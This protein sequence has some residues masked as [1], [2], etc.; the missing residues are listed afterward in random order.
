[1]LS[2][3]YGISAA[4]H[5]AEPSVEQSPTADEIRFSVAA[6]L[7][8]R[9]QDL[10]ESDNLA[11]LGM[12]SIRT[13]SMA[14]WF[15][16]RGVPV[17]FLELVD[18]PTIAQ[19]SALVGSRLPEQRAPEDAAPPEAAGSRATAPGLDPDAP[20]PLTPV[21]HAYWIGRRDDQILGSV[22]CHAYFEF[23]GSSL[24]PERLEAAVRTVI[25]RHGMLRAVFLDDGTQ[26]IAPGGNW[27]GLTVHDLRHPLERPTVE[28]LASVRDALSHRRLRVE[29]GEVLDVQ[30]S[31][32]PG[33]A[34]RLHLNV[35]LLVA[36]VESIRILLADLAHAY[37][38]PE[39]PWVHQDCPEQ[40]WA[41]DDFGFAHY[42]ADQAGRRAEAR[43]QART[44][45]QG[46]LAD[47][48]DGPVLPLA[49]DPAD[50]GPPRFTRRRHR[51]EPDAWQRFSRRARQGGTTPAMA[52]AAA[53]AEVLGSFSESPRFLLSLPLFDRDSGHPAVCDMVADFTNLLLVTVDLTAGSSFLER[54]R[55]LQEEFRAG[56]AHSAYSGVEVLR[57]LARERPDEPR[58]APVVFACTLGEELAG[59][60]VRSVLGELGWMISQTPQVWLD[61][62]VYESGGGVEL[63]WDSVD[64][65]FPPELVVDMFACYREL[66]DRQASADAD[67]SAPARPALPA[68]QRSVR[69]RVNATAAPRSGRLLHEGFFARA[70]QVP[71]APALLWGTDSA[72]GYGSLAR[73]AL[74]VAAALLARGL[75]PGEPVAVSA[76]RGADQVAAVL[77]VLAAGGA[78]VP[79]GID[80][81]AR[82]RRRILERAG[83][84]LLLAEMPAPAD[85]PPGVQVLDLGS[86]VEHP[87]LAEPVPVSAEA[88]AYVIFTSGTTGE[89]KGVQV[90][91]GAAVNTVEDIN[92]RFSVG[93]SDRVLA[94]SALD[95]DLSVYDLFGLLAAGGAVVLPDESQRRDP[96]AWAE[97]ITRHRVTVWNSV[98]VLLDM[99]LTASAASTASTATVVDGLRLA[100]VSGDWIGLDLPGRLA[101]QSGSRFVALGGATEAAIWSNYYEVTEVPAS[102]TSVPYGFPLRNQRFRVVGPDGLDRPDRVA[103]ELWIGGAGVALGYLGDAGLTAAKF[104]THEG[105]RW[106]RTGDRGRY[107]PDGTL[108]FLGRID[109]QLKIRGVRTEPGEIES[110][111]RSHPAIGHCTVAAVGEDRAKRLLAVITASPVSVPALAAAPSDVPLSAEPHGAE[112]QLVEWVLARLAADEAGITAEPAPL[113]ELARRWGA[114]EEWQPL[115]RLWFDWLAAR[116]VLTVERDGYAAGPKLA[117]VCADAGTPDDQLA[118]VARRLR[119][120]LGDLAAV[121]R[122]E[123]DPLVLLDDPVLAPEA[124]AAVAPG[125]QLAVVALLSELPAGSGV[126]EI[127]VLGASGGRTALGLA[128]RAGEHR[129]TLLDESAARLGAA[130]ELLTDTPGR[131][132]YHRLPTGLLPAEL[133][134]RFDVVVAD[135]S[136]HGYADSATG[137]QLAVLLLAPGGLLLALERTVLPPLALIAAALPTR[138]FTRL[139][140]VRRAR[141]TPLLPAG[142]W[143]QVLADAGLRPAGSGASGA[144]RMDGQVL[145]RATRTAEA[146]L[147]TEQAIREWLA[148]RLP[149]AMI[150][151]HLFGA[152]ALPITANGKVDRAALLR[153]LPTS[154]TVPAGPAVGEPPSGPLES[155]IAAAWCEVLGLTGVGREQNFFGLGGD[156]LLATRLVRRLRESG[157]ELDLAAVFSSPVLKDLA[158]AAA[159]QPSTRPPSPAADA[160]TA[161]PEHRHDPFPPTDVQRAYWTGRAVG[162]PLGGVGAHYYTE[163]DGTGLDLARLEAAWNQLIAR[164]EMLRAVF[165]EHGEQRILAEVPHVPIPVG[166]AARDEAEE[167]LAAFRAAMSHQVRDPARWP[168]VDLR[169]LVYERD[170]EQRVRLGVSLENIVL[171]GRS[172]MIVLAELEQLYHAPDAVLRP[173]DGL[174]FRDYLLR[175]VPA[176][177]SD[178]ARRYWQDRLA[179]LPP[180]PRLPLAAHPSE[181]GTPRFVRR[182]GLLPADRWQ[183]VTSRARAY[184]LTP[185]AVLLAC[186]AE[187]LGRWSSSPELTVN[188]TLFDRQDVHPGV[189]DIVGDFTSLLLVAYQPEP[190]AGFLDRARALQQ[191]LGQDLS[192]RAWSAVRVV[193]ELARA[194]G[195]PDQGMPDQGMPVVFTSALGTPRALSLDLAD[196]LLPRVWGVSQTPQTW[197]DNQVY[198]SARGLHYDW[199][200]VEQLLPA[201]VLDAMFAAYGDLLDR[202]AESDWTAGV[203][204]LLP[205]AQLAVRTRVNATSGPLART[206]LHERFFA[207]A[208]QAPDRTAC[209]WAGGRLG[210]GELALRARQIAGLLHAHGIRPGCAVAVHLPK[211]PEQ[212]AAV[213]GVLAA[214]AAYVPIGVDQPAARRERLYSGAGVDC[215]LTTTARLEQAPEGVTVLSVGDAAGHDGY[216]PVEL[217]GEALAY[218]IFTSGSTGEPKGVEIAHQSALNTVTDVSERFGVGAED[219][220]LAVSALDFDLSVF[221]IFGPLSVGGSV[222]LIGEGERR[223]AQ[224]WLELIVEHRVSVWNSVPMLLEMLLAAARGPVPGLRLALVSGDWVGL[225]LKERLPGCRLV[226]L[227]GATEAS[228]WSNAWEV[229]G[230]PAGWPSIPYG[231]PLRNQWFRVVGSQ[232]RDCPD[233]VPGELWIGGAG[234]ALGYRGD[235][236]RTAE[237]F[238]EYGG[239]R[240]YRTGDLGRYRPDGRLEFLGRTDH[241]LKVSGHRIELGEIEAALAAHP[242]V[243]Q[244]VVTADDSAQRR[245]LVA[246]AVPKEGSATAREL[247]AFLAERLPRHAVPHTV[248]LWDALPLTANG[249]VDRSALAAAPVAPVATTG[250]EAPRTPAE[251]LVCTVWAEALGVPEPSRDSDFFALGGDSL[252]ATKVVARLRAA[253]AAQAAISGLFTAPL[254]ADFAATLALQAPPV[255]SAAIEADPAARH[256][257]FP[258]TELQRAYWVGRSAAFTLGGVGSYYYC[259]FDESGLDLARLEAAWDRLI[260]R[261]EMLRAVFDEDGSQ[262][263]LPEVPGLAIPVLDA[264]EAGPDALREELSHR[265]LDPSRWPLFDVRAVRHGDGRARVCVGLDY[266]LVDGLSMMILFSELDLLYRDPQAQLPPIGVSFRDYVCQLAPSPADAERSLDH[267]RGRVPTLPP[268]PALPLAVD[269]AAVARPRFVRRESRLAPEQWQ[270]L[271]A[272]ARQHG[273]TPSAVLLACYAQVLATWS[274]QPELTVALTLFDRR[275][276]HPDIDRVLGDFTSLLPVAHQPVPAESFESAV[277][278][279]QDRLWRDLDHRGAPILGLLREAAGSDG[280]AEAS[281][282]VVFT[283]ALGVD[284]ALSSAL[285]RPVWSV[286]Q[287]PQVWLDEQVMVRDGGLQLSWDAVEELFPGG[288]LDAMFAAH[289]ELLDRVCRADWSEQLAVLPPPDQRSVRARVN[290]TVGPLPTGLLH[291]GFFERAAAE[292][293]RCALRW[294]TEE[295]LDHGQ[296]TYGRLADRAL[297]IAAMLRARG[298]RSGEPVAVSL[299][300]GPDQI[301]AVLGVLAAGAAYLPIGPDQPA[302]R[303]ER[304]LASG[305]VRITLSEPGAAD[306]YQPLDAPVE[307]GGEALAYVIFTSGSTGEPKGVEIAH[308]SALNTVTDVSERFGVGAED[309]VLA[310]SALDFDL[311]VFDIFGPLSVGGSVVLIGEGERRDAQRWLE[312]IVEHRVSVWNSVPMLLEMLLAAARGPVPGL[313][314]ALV[315]G[316][317]VGLDLKE[318]LPGCRLVALGGAT[319]ASIWSNAWEVEGVPAGWPSIPYGFPLRN[320]WFRV[321]GSQGRDCPDWVPGELWIGGAGVALGY[322]GD[323]V[324]TA[325]KFVE[326]GGGRWYRTGDL[327]RY[328]PDGRLEFLG[329]TDHQLKVSGHRIEL[330]EIEAALTAHPA[331]RQAVVV[332]VGERGGYRLHAF[333]TTEDTEDT[334]DGH[335]GVQAPELLASLVDRLPPYARPSGLTL[336]DGLP[337]TAN[338]K[339]DRSAL[340]P[341]P[342]TA[343]EAAAGQGAQAPRGPVETALAEL[344]GELL[345][346]PAVPRDAGFF[347]LGGDSLQATRLVQRVRERFG[348]ELSLRQLLSEPTVAGLATFIER[349]RLAFEA[350]DTEEGEL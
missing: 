73:R 107:W 226:A 132:A 239:G 156:S 212:L 41:V 197:L 111:L 327:G 310:V 285:R 258:P 281:L 308:Q 46:R 220:V 103:G 210:Y 325:E 123:L 86:A 21:Q 154:S 97:L 211:G 33:G 163:F 10:Q 243:R 167:A 260:A 341:P 18:R 303:R 291:A 259:E 166:Y 66:I 110:A 129:Y 47:L 315:S 307:L 2:P 189:D 253:G 134:S 238:V 51:L 36:D 65:L 221:D 49:C 59:D 39:H 25:A 270:A 150:P 100:L 169:A 76:A 295:Q 231:F 67:W 265:I 316:D 153:L 126:L 272:R 331:V 275:D 61:H 199:D 330:G 202:L 56:A 22:G 332:P 162:L 148:A 256:Q 26:R 101:T 151:D 294:G 159:T 15:R 175:P 255:P 328:R 289:G 16:R 282:P 207:H 160:V 28:R 339:V 347:A 144:D 215:V 190:G 171:D 297:R 44:Y 147:P 20:F 152:T 83:L 7:S 343:P 64:E 244:A 345:G 342:P 48:P 320:Q 3:G 300:K 262:R 157:L 13:M 313:R 329:R 257:P 192:H 121:A 172:M 326:Y 145:L 333:V 324:R 1:M 286:S 178:T 19:W 54:A 52:L 119:Q 279:L 78:Y 27:P 174:S 149:A 293:G 102:W 77:G 164:H 269:P 106:Y 87:P 276:V 93:P 96:G 146:G 136:L 338:G 60:E 117:A 120:R 98:P 92:E 283:S 274:A 349:Q 80:Q 35:D 17:T 14:G 138:G 176:A 323:P 71:D 43:E 314:L 137:A 348:C 340:R 135:N 90:S 79:V 203:P 337:L 235:P 186:Y 206:A 214:G 224:R 185:S 288:L 4:G 200:A 142:E 74:G 38:S 6:L 131:F 141:R 232:G 246:H 250:G 12:D 228:I 346:R 273:F 183:A 204:D 105:E 241:Q 82:R 91:H 116:D 336:L 306:G 155:A 158:A 122:G 248:T 284:D 45:W 225:D 99:L 236:V 240:W 37:S 219:R 230:V 128:A 170:G 264:P 9:P 296:L 298:V 251:R 165:D 8:R 299:P 247:L 280:A 109:Q 242:A 268:P 30:L 112:A 23:D 140:P 334:T 94:V 161:D 261:H 114:P 108:E 179:D 62:Q 304:M 245:R 177:E 63:C 68:R 32:L 350:E 193:R 311:S 40:P 218:V 75:R 182:S 81:P 127:A 277:R 125:A 196:W 69:E 118:P 321:V 58:R 181:V 31:L 104:V 95:F 11:E 309:R 227:G 205:A 278:R 124:L 70:A 312:L 53:Y 188:L 319:E 301:A 143:R 173:V 252:L 222:V 133:L 34:T 194:S 85:L 302:A 322:R 266:L 5:G 267:W 42:L 335:A 180:A 305:G 216:G 317:W 187:V 191:R 229:E 184:G 287:T 139:D 223:D 72:V 233:W 237:K 24:D 290:A 113:A 201:D 195:T 88:P 168:L 55:F 213:L 254:L 234:V 344:W 249:K 50:L 271:Q 84:R 57:D 29:L 130:A 292:P 263:I 318:R 209:V 208:R 217:G 89:P 198:D 115:L